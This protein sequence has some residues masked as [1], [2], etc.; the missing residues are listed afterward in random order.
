VHKRRKEEGKARLKQRGQAVDW[1]ALA[2]LVTVVAGLAVGAW[3][4]WRARG[5]EP[6]LLAFA[7]FG[8][9]LL[10][11]LLR[12]RS[13]TKR[14]AAA[15]A[16]AILQKPMA[17]LTV[18]DW[19]KALLRGKV[20]AIPSEAAPASRPRMA[21]WADELAGG[22]ESAAPI[23]EKPKAPA[24]TGEGTLLDRL[25][26]WLRFPLALALALLAQWGLEHQTGSPTLSAAL[27]LG[28]AALCGWAVWAG[29]LRLA[30]PALEP[31][32]AKPMRIRLSLFG[33]AVVL[34]VFTYLA[35]SNNLFR[36]S[37]IV[38]WVGALGCMLLSMWEGSISLQALWTW[39][40]AKAKDFI[41]GVRTD[42]WPIVVLLGL[43][44]ICFFRFYK[45]DLVPY[46][47]WSDHAEKLLDVLDVLHG[48]YSIFFLR[49]TGR[50][51]FQFYL[52]AASVRLLGTGVSFLTLKIGTALM[53][54]FA[55]PYVYLFTRQLAGRLSALCAMLLAGVGMWPNTMSRFGL[56]F[57]LYMAF[58]APALFHLVR[59][60]R[61]KRSNDFLLCGFFTGMGLLGYSP[62]R[63][64]P[65]VVAAGVVIFMLHRQARGQRAAVF[66]WL[67][68]AGMVALVVFLPL[69][70]AAL[71][72]P[73]QFWSRALTRIS[74]LERPLPAPALTTF[75]SNFWHGLLMFNWDQGG[76]WAICIPHRPA[77]DWVSGSLFILGL[78]M[79]VV[80]YA[81]RRDWRDILLLL[82]IPL[83]MLPSTLSLAFP[84]E[85]PAPN[86][87][88]A[89]M[90][91]VFALA[92]MALASL[93]KWMRGKLRRRWAK[94]LGI[95]CL[96]ALFALAAFL[97]Y[98]LTFKDFDTEQRNVM[99]NSRE[100][101]DVL[102]EFI[103]ENG[104]FERAHIVPYPY[105]M[106]T[107]L[108]SI[109]AGYAGRDVALQ[110]G[111]FESVRLFPG[112]H[113]FLLHPDDMQDQ[114]L[115]QEM[116]P[117]G[118]LVRWVSPIEGKDFMMY[119]VTVE[120]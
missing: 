64:V 45:L 53:G 63:I 36:L 13:T 107:R 62:A 87:A 71:D 19:F 2:R 111:D 6:P 103:E 24:P 101:G 69:L 41:S 66:G 5:G 110:P 94:V 109:V 1:R 85:N 120:P 37:T 83:L 28:A 52:A 16:P 50:E 79:A 3:L 49:N 95:L 59:G 58:A 84:G 108:A 60:L 42:G 117:G 55:I 77:L 30:M 105:W 18:L 112:R 4:L 15:E 102:H 99:W 39:I 54:L 89:A 23:A 73:A 27:L 82:S 72:M 93:V 78:G 11:L 116:F 26:P 20:L 106:D 43:G 68:A 70:H 113:L 25:L 74:D 75:L 29:D 51:P 22:A 10:A 56:R 96:A 40:K 65:L 91:P 88:G 118:T 35:S 92:G 31:G 119:T 90:I 114:M 46:E 104:D 86:R 38:C 48:R 9:A 67:V 34:A 81:V 47:M 32:R 76:T 100:A 33:A 21:H 12:R 115:L 61:T 80:R 8:A 97:N 57:P 98:Q 7:A 14:A 17:E 44:L